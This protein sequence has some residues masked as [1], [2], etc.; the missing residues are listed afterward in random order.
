MLLWEFTG[1]PLKFINQQL[2]THDN[3]YATYLAIELAERTLNDTATPTYAKLKFP[4]K[5]P[6]LFPGP[7]ELEREMRAARRTC[8]TARGE[9]H[10][11][12]MTV[13]GSLN[14]Q[15]TLASTLHLFQFQI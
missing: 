2:K 11:H 15:R 9:S 12:Y 7:A 5:K 1:V 8:F 3:L 6:T 13:L 14:H 10:D 4:R